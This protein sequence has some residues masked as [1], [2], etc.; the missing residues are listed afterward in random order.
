MSNLLRESK[1]WDKQLEQGLPDCRLRNP[2]R[3]TVYR[4]Q[5]EYEFVYCANC[6]HEGALVTANWA[7]HVFYICDPCVRKV[8]PVNL[9]EVPTEVVQGKVRG[10]DR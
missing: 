2:D 3:K 5:M 6:G 7:T 4:G 10:L 1:N 9:P 8:G